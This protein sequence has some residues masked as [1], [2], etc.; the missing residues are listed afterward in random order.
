MHLSRIISINGVP[1]IG[2]KH[3]GIS[4]NTVSN[5][6]PKPP[7]KIM[8]SILDKLFLVIIEYPH[9]SNK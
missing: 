9:V 7:A 3:L 1:F 2:A 8:V 4:F 6:V 5:L